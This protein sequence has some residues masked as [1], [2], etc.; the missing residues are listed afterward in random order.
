MMGCSSEILGIYITEDNEVMLC[1]LIFEQEE[2]VLKT[3]EL[4]M[5]P[6][7]VIVN[8]DK[9]NRLL[10]PGSGVA[11]PYSADGKQITIEGMTATVYTDKKITGMKQN[12]D[13]IGTV[14]GKEYKITLTDKNEFIV[15]EDNVEVQK[16]ELT[17][18]SFVLDKMVLD[19][20]GLMVGCSLFGDRIV[21][22]SQGVYEISGTNNEIKKNVTY[23]AVSGNT[24]S[25]DNQNV[26]TLTKDGESTTL[27]THELKGDVMWE[28]GNYAIYSFAGGEIIAFIDMDTYTTEYYRVEK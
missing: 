14:D 10:K 18:E 2:D 12:T 24:L 22:D 1:A 5:Q 27:N 19:V 21:V 7:A 9:E 11:I 15:Y 4:V 20:D 17:T 13:Y 3:M 28:Q 16:I 6:L 23:K 8:I 25:I 26:I